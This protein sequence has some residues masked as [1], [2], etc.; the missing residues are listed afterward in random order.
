MDINRY[1][2]LQRTRVIFFIIFV[3]LP[4]LFFLIYGDYLLCDVI[5]KW[6]EGRLTFV[7]VFLI[8]IIQYVSSTIIY[9]YFSGLK[10]VILRNRNF[11]ES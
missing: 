9:G 3:T 7:S 6:W 11:F 4:L 2:A 1:K 10:A 5:M 8:S